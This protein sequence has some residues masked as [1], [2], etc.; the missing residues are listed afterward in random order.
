MPD[1][2]D[3][4]RYQP[5]ILMPNISYPAYQLYALAGD[6]KSDPET[7]LKICIL[8]TAAWLRKRF[9]KMHVPEALQLP[10]PADHEQFSLEQIESSFTDIGYQLEI[11]WIPE[12]KIWTLRL[13]EPDMGPNP[14]DEQQDRNPVPGRLIETNVSYCI[15]GNRVECGFKTIISEPEGTAAGFEV[16]RYS[17]IKNIARN[18]NAGM[19]QGPWQLLDKSHNLKTRGSVK[20]LAEWLDDETRMVPAVII[21]EYEKDQKETREIKEITPEALVQL[22][23]SS[24]TYIES[25]L[26]TD[27]LNKAEEINVI[28]PKESLINLQVI[29]GSVALPRYRMGFAQY[30]ALQAGMRDYFIDRTGIIIGSGEIIIIEPLIFE[31]KIH[32]FDCNGFKSDTKRA[33]NEIDAFIEAYPLKRELYFGDCIFAAEAR[34]MELAS[35]L[36]TDLE[37]LNEEA[38][39]ELENKRHEIIREQKRIEKSMY[40]QLK[41]KDKEISKAKEK[42]SKL[43]KKYEDTI[44][45]LQNQ[46]DKLLKEIE[47]K[48]EYINWQQSKAKRP[49]SF[50][51]VVDWVDECFPGRLMIHAKTHSKLKNAEPSK[52]NLSQVCDALEYLATEYRLELI[53]EISEKERNE[54]SSLKYGRLFDVTPIKGLAAKALPDYK[55]KYYTG[56][57][58]KP[59]ESVLDLHLKIGNDNEN[60][61]RIY[62]LYDKEK[63]LIVV[64]SLP[65]HLPTF[66]DRT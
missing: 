53:G 58:G 10:A 26:N 19:W 45:E 50:A 66:T 7:V 31:K 1:I 52:F 24:E 14:G 62:F 28:E 54:L 20:N 22:L 27:S 60:L 3:Q 8:E 37:K 39:T 51:G 13:E 30:F 59:A 47:R 48:N 15:T 44:L 49:A 46:N 32:R 25:L 56:A 61:L 41:E 43:Q 12:E 29:P 42:T 2:K 57:A 18:R 64:G 36:L 17:C 9:R 35:V 21:S 33:L 55:I 34:L 63:K 11:I 5:V 4:N 23:P 65:E 16:Y 38:F 6:E 40:G